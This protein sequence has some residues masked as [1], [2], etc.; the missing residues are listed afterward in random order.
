MEVDDS[1]S[2]RDEDNAVRRSIHRCPW[3]SVAARLHARK[4]YTHATHDL[5]FP[6]TSTPFTEIEALSDLAQLRMLIVDANLLEALQVPVT[7][8]EDHH[9]ST[10]P[11]IAP[12][13]F[14][15]C[16]YLHASSAFTALQRGTTVEDGSLAPL[17]AR[18][19]HLACQPTHGVPPGQRWTLWGSFLPSESRLKYTA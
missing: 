11:H 1:A 5:L 7:N 8:K 13:K 12:Q 18:H 17:A 16:S 15:F 19:S 10:G 14:I 3:P 9:A 2:S 4:S 6:T